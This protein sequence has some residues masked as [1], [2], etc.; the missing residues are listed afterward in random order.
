MG[1]LSRILGSQPDHPPL[2]SS[3]PVASH[4]EALKEPI[5]TLVKQLPDP[6]E[7]VPTD[8]AAYAFIGNPPKKF[9]IAW[10]DAQGKVRN[11]KSLVEEQGLSV[12]TLEK[13]SEELKNAYIRGENEER[14]TARVDER[15]VVVMP[16]ETLATDVREIIRKYAN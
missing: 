7:I 1:F 14:F 10:V 12:V 2:D 13:L 11:F 8:E 3:H 16:S 5:Q 4:L 6:L 15:E 9:G